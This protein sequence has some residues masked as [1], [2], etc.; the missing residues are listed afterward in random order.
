MVLGDTLS[1]TLSLILP[2]GAPGEMAWGL[3]MT[4]RAT[5][6]CVQ[7]RWGL[8][9][10]QLLLPCC[11]HLFFPDGRGVQLQDGPRQG[12]CPG[13]ATERKSP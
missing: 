9:F 8:L 5:I 7:W 1:P 4:Q 11:P 13:V 12:G 2:W 6:P 10:L 3:D